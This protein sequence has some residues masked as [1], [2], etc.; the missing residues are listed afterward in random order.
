MSV[1]K[2]PVTLGNARFTVYTPGCVRIEYAQ[3]GKFSPYPSLIAGP[4]M[5]RP[6]AAEVSRR[7]TSLR[8]RT[9]KF[10]L[11]YINNGEAFTQ[12]NL[13]ITHKN[14]TGHREVWVP[15]KKDAGN[16]GSVRRSLDQW[17]WCG[18]PEHYPVE[19]ILSTQGG[20]FL[21]D[22]ARVY[23]NT[24]Y[25][26]PENLSP[27]V[28]FDGYFFAYGDD[29]KAALKDFITVFGRI[30][31][32]PRWAFGFWYS[33]WHAYK[34]AELVELTKRY[35]REGMPIDVMVI[36]TDWRDGWG[37]YDWSRKYFPK[38]KKAMED[39]HRLGLHT[40]LNDHPGYDQYDKLPDSDSHIPAIE[41]RLGPL[42]HQGQWAC[43]WSNKKALQVWREEILGP[44]FDDG[45]DFWWID[46]WCR[47]PF[48]TLDSQLWLNRQYYE[49]SEQ[50]TGKRGMIL[51]RWGGVGSHRYPVQFSGDTASEWGVLQYQI[52]LTARSAGLGAVYWSHDIGG[53]FA[54]K[55]D[56]E[57]YIRW[58]QFG[59]LSPVFRTHSSHGLREPWNYSATAQ[60]VFRKQTRIRYALMPYLYTLAREAHDEGLPLV[61]PLYLEYNK[62]DGGALHRKQQYLLG[63][64]VLVMPADG[65]GDPVTGVF[66]KRAYF[67]PGVWYG[68]ETD[69]VI[70]GVQDRMVKIPRDLIATYVRG[71]AIVPCERVADCV[72][73]RA[74]DE[75]HF[76]Y[77]PSRTE[78]SVYE[79]Y[80]DDGET[81]DYS[82]RAWARTKLEGRR[83]AESIFF[84]IHTP[85]GSYKGMPRSRT[86]IV[87]MRLDSGERVERVEA[88]V[89][90]HAWKTV[91]HEVVQKS[92]A[93]EVKSG[94]RFCQA[95]VRSAREEVQVRALLA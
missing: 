27:Q 31:M 66:R 68:L 34:A 83:T 53:F 25:H 91:P 56:D 14:I 45:M 70:H 1:Q 29:F 65:P 23:W 58:V 17:Q 2:T 28:G 41:R 18:G 76:D 15:G 9:E 32:V 21:A 88:K 50:K 54:D 5:P 82:G 43:D 67:P 59:S 35:R 92:L 44:L 73:D 86:Y 8:I 72:R 49:L 93:G 48:G 57:L 13:K 60:T 4:A 37:G 24:K 51:S 30:P 85:R 77:Y 84:T 89:G 79:L 22:D 52:E 64:D 95:E 16:F 11:L 40:S 75:I 81:N 71:G 90:H 36:D 47:P 94:H 87:R 61:R 19:G 69:E 38:P 63:R 7:G 3:G 12:D 42:P 80:E 78:P 6:I 20:H 55:V 26:W 74:M 39:L 46:G 10:E 33:R 62:N